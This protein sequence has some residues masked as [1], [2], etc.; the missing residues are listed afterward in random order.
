MAA[1]SDTRLDAPEN[2]SVQEMRVWLPEAE[3]E[4]AKPV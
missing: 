4:L 2:G 3:V 1:C